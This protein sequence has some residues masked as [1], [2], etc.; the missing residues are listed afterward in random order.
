[1]PIGIRLDGCIP[2]FGRLQDTSPLLRKA[3]DYYHKYV[4]R[5]KEEQD[6]VA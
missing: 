3:L 5:P 4:P 6:K 1:M 2:C